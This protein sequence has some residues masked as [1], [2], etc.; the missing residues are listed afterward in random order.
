MLF[1][2]DIVLFSTN[3][4]EVERKAENWRKSLE[5]IKLKINRKK[6]EYMKFCKEKGMEVRLQEEILKRGREKE[7][8]PRRGENYIGKRIMEMRV[9]EVRV[10]RRPK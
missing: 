3:R 10:R 5:D 1:A 4:D 8:Y 2:N 7:E 6:T 9:E